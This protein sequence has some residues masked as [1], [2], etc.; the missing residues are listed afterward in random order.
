M[1]RLRIG[2]DL[3]GT[4][5]EAIALGRRWQASCC[6]AVSRRRKETIP[7]PCGRSPRWSPRLEDQLGR[8]G[9][10]G[11]G[12]PGA[13][14]LANGRIKNANSTCLIGQPLRGDLET[15]LQRELRWPT[16]PTASRF[17]KPAT[18]PAAMPRSSSESFSAPASA[19]ASSSAAMS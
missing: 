19:A 15:L 6:A 1:S 2:V 12:I 10:V 7:R 16:M 5:I 18:A 13:E 4:K 17:P 9:T 8:S 11:I 14:S 3:G